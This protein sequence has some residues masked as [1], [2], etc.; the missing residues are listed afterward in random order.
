MAEHRG[1]VVKTTG[2]GMLVEIA[3]LAEALRDG[4]SGGDDGADRRRDLDCRATTPQDPS[5][6]RFPVVQVITAGRPRRSVG[7]FLA[8]KRGMRRHWPS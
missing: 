2:D 4:G 7:S 5:S 8:K 1:R 6:D 3:G